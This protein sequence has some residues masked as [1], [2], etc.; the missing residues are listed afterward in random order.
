MLVNV[1]VWLILVTEIFALSGGGFLS[2]RTVIPDG[3]GHQQPPI[4]VL[5]PSV[6]P[7]PNELGS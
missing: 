5:E 4:F 1:H 7:K 3:P 2:F 6:S